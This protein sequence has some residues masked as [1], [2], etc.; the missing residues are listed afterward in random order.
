[1]FKVFLLLDL[2]GFFVSNLKPFEWCNKKL[3]IHIQ[4]GFKVCMMFQFFFVLN[5]DIFWVNKTYEFVSFKKFE[6]SISS[7]LDFIKISYECI[8]KK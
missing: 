4:R 6:I 5:F 2:D 1:M 3:Q 8:L 7:Y